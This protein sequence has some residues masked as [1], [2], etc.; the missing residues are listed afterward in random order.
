MVIDNEAGEP[1]APRPEPERPRRSIFG[2]TGRRRIGL[3]TAGALVLG[4]VAGGASTALI[5]VHRHATL[6]LQPAAIASLENDSP[7]AIK[8]QV[9]EI[10]GNKLVV[11]DGSG[12]ALVETGPEGE[13]RSLAAKGETITA[14][15]RFDH[16]VLRAEM[17][18]EA[19]GKVV[20]LGP[21]KP[22]RGPHPHGPAE[23][24]Q[25]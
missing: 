20:D 22:P 14:Q 24:A 5:G 3:A 19:S 21:P 23:L 11:D 15:G 8:G 4:L 2:T 1:A 18:V 6:V 17:L 25:R 9:A 12:R 13:G 7:A 10:F 16:G